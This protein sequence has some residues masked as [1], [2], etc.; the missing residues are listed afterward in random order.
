MNLKSF[1]HNNKFF[2]VL[3][4]KIKRFWYK[5]SRKPKKKT[6]SISKTKKVFS[7]K[8]VIFIVGII[9]IIL[10]LAKLFYPAAK[11]I[12]RFDP[13][14]L[15][16]SEQRVD[17]WTGSSRLT[18]LTLGV[19][20]TDSAHQFVDAAFI[21]IL[22]PKTDE[23]A[24]FNINPDI[25]VAYNQDGKQ[26]SIRNILN[27]PGQDINSL[28]N[29]IENLL[30]I[31]VDRYIYLDKQGFEEIFSDLLSLK[32]ELARDIV[33]ADLKNLKW[34]KGQVIVKPQELLA[35]LSANSN[36]RDEQMQRQISVMSELVLNMSS[37][38]VVYNT[39]QILDKIDAYLK[40]DLS[41][42]EFFKLLIK[43]NKVKQDHIKYAYTR[44]LA[45]A[46][47]SKFGVYK[48]YYINTEI[49]DD[50]LAKILL[51]TEILKEQATME[52]F[53][54]T[55]I[56][57]L[58]NV[59]ARW[60]T[61]SGGRVLHIGNNPEKLTVSKAYIKYPEQYPNTI[62][63]LKRIFN[64]KLEITKEEYKYRHLGDIVIIIG[65]QYE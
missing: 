31:R 12:W 62:A 37:L 11:A 39:P 41:K 9:G 63:E 35:F 49:L 20:Q 43:I 55:T 25:L 19:D 30:A 21:M 52:I 42:T 57:G 24:I 47:D 54:G 27:I 51:N 22:D 64:N 40:T 17:N 60:I 58:A 34:Q 29:G 33:D 50:D 14:S 2:N 28:I 5:K 38:R 23:L 10:I 53:N 61:N 56:K 32:I 46:E 48:K 65:S 1:L 13:Q 6:K 4:I 26:N 15:E 59:K 36:G 16:P 45:L 7:K 3:S 44:S 8:P 18:L